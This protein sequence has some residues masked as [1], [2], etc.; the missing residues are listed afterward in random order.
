[1]T[2]DEKEL[3]RQKALKLLKASNEMLMDA[4][5]NVMRQKK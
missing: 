3:E 2:Q 5:K 1:M 4:K